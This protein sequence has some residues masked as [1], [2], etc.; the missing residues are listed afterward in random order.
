MSLMLF[1]VWTKLRAWVVVH[2]SLGTMAMPMLATMVNR[3]TK[4]MTVNVPIRNPPAPTLHPAPDV[5]QG[6]RAGQHQE[7][8]EV[9]QVAGRDVP[10]EQQRG[11][12]RTGGQ[13][14]DPGEGDLPDRSGPE[15]GHHAPSS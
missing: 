13:Q 2:S 1:W 12:G 3:A 6:H 10:P 5:G 8:Y 9:S 4:P 15:R 11:T 7:G 14:G